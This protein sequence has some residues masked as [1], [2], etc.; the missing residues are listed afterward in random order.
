MDTA[1][2]IIPLMVG[3]NEKALQFSKLLMQNG[4]FAVPIRPPTVPSNTARIRFSITSAHRKE[5]LSYTTKIIKKVGKKLNI[6]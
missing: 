5:E 4:I 1:T 2:Q 6:I 3:E